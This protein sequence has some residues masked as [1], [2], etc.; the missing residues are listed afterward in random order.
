MII[1]KAQGESRKKNNGTYYELHHIIP[2]SMGGNN[3][4]QNLVLLT[5]REHYVC[6]LLLV[7]SVKNHIDKSNMIKAIFILRKSIRK[8]HSKNN[9][10]CYQ[11]L[12]TAYAAW[13]SENFRRDK[14]PMF[15]QTHSEE[16][17]AKI[18]KVREDNKKTT[19][20][21]RAINPHS[22]KITDGT[23]IY[24][25]Q[26]EA[27]E[28]TGL[29]R[30]TI[31]RKIETNDGWWI[32]SN[33][34]KKQPTISEETRKKIS[35]TN[36]GKSL[37]P[38]TKKK[39]SISRKGKPGAVWSD[40]RKDYY[41]KLYKGRELWKVSGSKTYYNKDTDTQIRLQPDDTIPDG[42]V[43][44]NRPRKIPP[45]AN[46]KACYNPTSGHKTFIDKSLPLPEGYQ[47]GWT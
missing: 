40:E 11:I 29:N 45:N 30:K 21:L 39:M 9:S 20:E 5:A 47:L 41:R 44:G 43:P 35:A 25:S 7:K 10:L 3:K 23:N 17:K 32:I 16:A 24:T 28:K 42:F 2:R 46:K 8:N 1:T 31:R 14:N 15:G 38:E 13:M 6:H 22:I 19:E 37:S 34:H 36:S 27:A 33:D 26:R 18:R 12:R 4:K